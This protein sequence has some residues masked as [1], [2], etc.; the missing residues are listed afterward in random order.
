MKERSR[1][2]R[3]VMT[4]SHRSSR[5][6]R[7]GQMRKGHSELIEREE[8]TREGMQCLAGIIDLKQYEVSG[9]THRANDRGHGVCRMR[10]QPKANI[11]T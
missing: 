2:G 7:D 1:N 10:H 3:K 5:I 4:L 8:V 11:S 9:I 6:K